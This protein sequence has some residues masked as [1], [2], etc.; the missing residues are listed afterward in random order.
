M[1]TDIHIKDRNSQKHFYL[2]LF[3]QKAN[4]DLFSFSVAY[5]IG[6]KIQFL[7]KSYRV[8]WFHETE[9]KLDRRSEIGEKNVST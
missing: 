6:S 5:W 1:G 2:K 3:A 8:K 4:H 9:L 7:Q